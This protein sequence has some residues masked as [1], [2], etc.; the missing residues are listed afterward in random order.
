MEQINIL[1][2]KDVEAKTGLKTSTLYWQIKHKTF[3]RPIKLGEK[4]CGWLESE[5]NQWLSD[6][7][8]LRDSR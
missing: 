5:V 4:S 8:A 2:R 3:P 6:K 7:V 1:R